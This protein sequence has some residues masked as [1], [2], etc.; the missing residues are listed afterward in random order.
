M[1]APHLEHNHHSQIPTYWNHLIVDKYFNIWI[2][3]GHNIQIIAINTGSFLITFFHFSTVLELV[4]FLS[5]RPNTWCPQPKGGGI[6]CLFALRDTIHSWRT[7]KQKWHGGRA[8]KGLVLTSWQPGREEQEQEHRLPD[9]TLSDHL[10]PDPTSYQCVQR[11]THQCMK[12]LISIAPSDPI[13]SP[14]APPL[15][16]W[17]F[18]GTF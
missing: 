4:S 12:P 9:H 14:K 1:T 6:V 11:W 7:P 16:I 10:Q 8:W 3:Q 2:F 18:W 17:D 15:N 5:L 13:T